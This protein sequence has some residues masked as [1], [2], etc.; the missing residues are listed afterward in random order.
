MS[1]NDGPNC[2]KIAYTRHSVA[3]TGYEP[4]PVAEFYRQYRAYICNA[5]LLNHV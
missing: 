1:L 2:P 3:E 5:N 4:V